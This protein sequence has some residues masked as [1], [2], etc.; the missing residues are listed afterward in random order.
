[1]Q[2]WT[3]ISVIAENQQKS[4]ALPVNISKFM[5]IA[6]STLRPATQAIIIMYDFTHEFF[7]APN[8]CKQSGSLTISP[9]MKMS[10]T[11]FPS[12]KTKYYHYE[13]DV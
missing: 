7:L 5:P 9:T 4:V 2:N 8:L 12:G 13:C 11:S 10:I 3:N 1:M 6:H